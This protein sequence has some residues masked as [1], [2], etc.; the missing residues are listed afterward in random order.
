MDG[1]M[2]G[3]TARIPDLKRKK[4]RRILVSKKRKATSFKGHIIKH[5]SQTGRMAPNRNEQYSSTENNSRT[6]FD[7]LRKP[8]TV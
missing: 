7:F 6:K 1:W 3:Q 4:R 8:R 2:D 5:K